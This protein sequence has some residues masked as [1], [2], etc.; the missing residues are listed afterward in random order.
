VLAEIDPV[1]PVEGYR[2][3]MGYNS[4]V[5]EI[6]DIR[7][8][9]GFAPLQLVNELV[10]RIQPQKHFLPFEQDELLLTVRRDENSHQ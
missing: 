6:V 3:A 2:I 10:T 8:A 5:R 7:G 4:R 1:D 9:D